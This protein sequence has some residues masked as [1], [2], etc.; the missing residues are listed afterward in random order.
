M[1]RQ[2]LVEQMFDRSSIKSNRLSADVLS[3]END[4]IYFLQTTLVKMSFSRSYPNGTFNDVLLCFLTVVTDVN[5]LK[6]VKK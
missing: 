2:R 5:K 1:E 4:P 3:Y 6:T